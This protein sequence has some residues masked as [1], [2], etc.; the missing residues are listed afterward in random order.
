MKNPTI[1]II[2]LLLILKPLVL[3]AASL[4]DIKKNGEFNI[5]AHKDALPFSNE[6]KSYGMHIDLAKLMADE[7]GV[8]LKTS[9]VNLPRYAKYVNC[10]AYMGVSILPGEAGG[11]GFVK[12]TLPQVH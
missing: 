12:K 2:L 10:D 4:S 7:L 3:S 1:L 8:S 5:C 9:W 11:E 6:K